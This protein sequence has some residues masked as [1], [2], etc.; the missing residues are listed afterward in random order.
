MTELDACDLCKIYSLNLNFTHMCHVSRPANVP[1]VDIANINSIFVC[2]N[3]NDSI[4]DF[5]VSNI[6]T[7]FKKYRCCTG[8]EKK[9][10]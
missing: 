8:K 7:A 3:S 4:I 1:T 2:W 9:Q 6:A 5:L 10:R